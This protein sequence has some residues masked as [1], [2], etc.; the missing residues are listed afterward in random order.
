MPRKKQETPTQSTAAPSDE[1]RI[2]TWSGTTHYQCLRCPFDTFDRMAM[3]N[4]LVEAH[5]SE[6]ALE[7]MISLETVSPSSIQELKPEEK[8]TEENG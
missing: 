1:Y 4:H 5:N 6:V 7:T 8:E 2:G 3:L